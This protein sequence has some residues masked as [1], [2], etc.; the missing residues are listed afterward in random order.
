[1]AFLKD[2]NLASEGGGADLVG[3]G[4]GTDIQPGFADQDATHGVGKKR[5]AEKQ[6]KPDLTEGFFHI[7]D[8]VTTAAAWTK[9]RLK[10][11]VIPISIGGPSPPQ[12]SRA[13]DDNLF[14]AL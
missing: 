12:K 7:N 6:K 4:V 13:Q 8:C 9:I 5:S 1:M 10:P 11:R 2:R 3:S 14:S